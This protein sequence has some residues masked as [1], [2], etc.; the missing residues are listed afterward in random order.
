MANKYLTVLVLA[1]FLAI[2][3]PA[4]RKK[5]SVQANPSGALSFN[6]EY[7]E[8]I[9]WRELGPFRGGRSVTVTGVVG[10][11]NTYY[12]GGVGGG[13]WKSEDA[14]QTWFNITDKY[15]GGTIGEIGRAHV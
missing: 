9:R 3:A 4:Q 11:P 2:D 8:G 6:Q 14:G 12:F 15:F 1:A 5:G 10:D 13:V 7:Y